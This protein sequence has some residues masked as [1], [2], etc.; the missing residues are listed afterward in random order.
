MDR[1]LRIIFALT[2][3]ALSMAGCGNA[4]EPTVGTLVGSD[5]GKD[6]FGQ[7]SLNGEHLGH[8]E[9]YFQPFDFDVAEHP[10]YGDGQ[11]TG[12]NVLAVRVELR[13][14]Q[15]RELGRNEFAL[16]IEPPVAEPSEEE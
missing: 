16:A 12:R 13:D 9:G 2:V 10:D 5:E 1:M 14:G 4:A 8:H 11:R 7:V 15:G 3:L 6:S